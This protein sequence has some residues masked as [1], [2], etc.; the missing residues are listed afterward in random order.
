MKKR[1]TLIELLVVIAIISI[2]AAMLLPALGKAREKARQ[3]SCVNNLKSIGTGVTQ[4][5]LDFNEWFPMRANSG[6]KYTAA[7]I[8]DYIGAYK[9]WECPAARFKTRL[10]PDGKTS[11]HIGIESCYGDGSFTKSVNMLAICNKGK[12]TPSTLHFAADAREEADEN[13]GR[14]Q[15]GETYLGTYGWAQ[16][17]RH[18]SDTTYNMQYMDGHVESFNWDNGK[19]M[20]QIN[21]E[22]GGASGT[23]YL[24]WITLY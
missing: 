11:M 13:C 20:P 10:L 22:S 4:Y 7:L 18:L 23:S 19:Y 24:S 2:L 9:V 14:M 3:T 6:G 21:W 12:N 1:F 5:T 8:Y 17:H 16:G 15:Y